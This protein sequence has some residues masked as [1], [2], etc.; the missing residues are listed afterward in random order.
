MTLKDFVAERGGG[1]DG[2]SNRAAGGGNAD[3]PGKAKGLKL[4]LSGGGGAG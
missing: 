4:L 1:H 2:L 3:G